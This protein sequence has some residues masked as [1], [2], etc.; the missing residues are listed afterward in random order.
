MAMV[1]DHLYKSENVATINL[2]EYI[3]RL[4][5]HISRSRTN[6]KNEIL[7]NCKFEEVLIGLEQAVPLS[8]ALNEILTNVFKHAT[9][10]TGQLQLK[11][12]L[13]NL[14]PTEIEI[15]IENNG[16]GLG[17]GADFNLK[18]SHSLGLHLI[19]ILIE[20]QL[21]DRVIVNRIVN[22]I[23]SPYPANQRPCS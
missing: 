10:A 3:E 12:S 19:Q 23:L 11:L 1:H 8:L 16:N 14:G 7:V 2:G 17:L 20:D 6:R 9:P 13:A 21:N 5:E 15:N 18:K 22:S 4:V